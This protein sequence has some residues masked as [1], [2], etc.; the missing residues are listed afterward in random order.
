MEIE[1]V[2]V[3]L[4]VIR[5]VY[6]I[7]E[8]RSSALK[9]DQTTS[10]MQ[11]DILRLIADAAER[12]AS[13]IHVVVGRD[14]AIVRVRI[15]GVMRDL[16]EW[17]VAYGQDFC[18]AVFAMAD[19]SDASY[20]P[21]EYQGARISDTS[22]RLAEGVQSVRLQFNPLAMGGR[23]LVMR[24]LYYSKTGEVKDVDTLGYA[25]PQIN[26]IKRMRALPMGINIIAGPTGSGKSTT[27]QRCLS[28]LIAER[29]REISV[30]TI[31]DPP[32]YV[33][34]GAQQ[35]PVTNA[36][37]PEERM[38]KFHQA[39]NAA[40]RSD[41]NVIMIGEIR[42]KE[43]AKLAF[44]A[45]MTGH[46]V[47][48]TLHA[49]DAMTIVSRLKDIG[50]EP[51][52][53]FDPTIVTGLIGQRLMRLCCPHCSIPF[54]DAYK[55]KRITEGLWKRTMAVAGESLE[56]IKARG[57]GCEKCSHTG[58]VGR[59]V[60]AEVMLPDD[61]IMSLLQEND[62]VTSHDYWVENLAGMPMM[63]H[64]IMKIKDGIS[65]PDEVERVLGPLETA[66]VE[67]AAIAS[68]GM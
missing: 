62:K 22:V 61:K 9:A 55:A 29:R 51:Y 1:R 32:E 21:Y 66:A 63:H 46:Q 41:P 54:E 2:K 48:A 13:D 58:A 43:S 53:L 31:E 11:R 8:Q 10:S 44:E 17:R 36:N 26:L 42:D 68:Q 23:H 39:I 16:H 65:S 40:L 59:T 34:E 6:L 20:Q 64:G 38:Q 57:D 18:A 47:W 27:L 49:T 35:M 52:K 50:V 37:T 14:S 60:V 7:H 19:A 12:K 33:I 28:T 24:L 56:N 45:A 4:S 25:L 5:K 3:D 15:D 67:L 30:F